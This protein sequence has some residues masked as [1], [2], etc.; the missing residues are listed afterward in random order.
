MSMS[1]FA[2]DGTINR[3]NGNVG[4][5]QGFIVRHLHRQTLEEVVM[6]FGLALGFVLSAVVAFASW[7]N[8][9]DELQAPPQTDPAIAALNNEFQSLN[10]QQQHFINAIGAVESN[11]V[12]AQAVVAKQ[13]A[14]KATLIEWLK[15]AQEK[16]QK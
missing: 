9:A 1:R 14:E 4:K 13:E 8:A 3:V 10:T 6:K 5:S 15:A 2:F 16:E 11:L 12:A 7:A